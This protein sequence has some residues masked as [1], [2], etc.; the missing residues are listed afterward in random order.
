MNKKKYLSPLSC[1]VWLNTKSTILN[2]SS[3]TSNPNEGGDP[4]GGGGS[5]PNPFGA[6][7]FDG[8]NDSWDDTTL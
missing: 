2:Y 3:E 5:S 7:K 4:T 8:W 6:K 1:I